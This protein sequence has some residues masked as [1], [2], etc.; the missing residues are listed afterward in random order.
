MTGGCCQVVQKLVESLSLFF[1]SGRQQLASI[2][3]GLLAE[4]V[5]EENRNF[6]WSINSKAKPSNKKDKK[7]KV[8]AMIVSFF[9]FT[10]AISGTVALIPLKHLSVI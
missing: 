8:I 1:F 9:F 7:A 3:G 5:L 4:R 6:L 10:F 2:T